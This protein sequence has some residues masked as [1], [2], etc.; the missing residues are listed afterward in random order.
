MRRYSTPSLSTTNV[1][2]SAALALRKEDSRE[3]EGAAVHHH[4]EDNVTF[5]LDS[6]LGETSFFSIL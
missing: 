2:Y 5:L 6:M 1:D 4:R 3:G